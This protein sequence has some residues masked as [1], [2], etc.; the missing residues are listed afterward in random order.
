MDFLPFYPMK[1]PIAQSYGELIKALIAQSCG[2][3]WS[4]IL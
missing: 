2:E 3:L 1:A 4:K